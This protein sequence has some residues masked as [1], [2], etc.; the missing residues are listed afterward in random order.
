MNRK[1]LLHKR[2]IITGASM[3][4]GKEIAI[5]VAKRGGTPILIARSKEKLQSLSIELETQF[6]VRAPYYQIDVG[7]SASIKEGFRKIVA[8]ETVDVLINNAG[9]GIFAYFE[10]MEMAEAEEMFAVNVLGLIACTKA[11]LPSMIAQKHGQ[12]INIASQAGKLAT[13]KSSVYAATKH[14]VLGFSNSLRMEVA[15]HNLNVSTVNPGPIRTSFYARADRAGTY[16]QNVG[17]WL[18]SSE[19][20]AKRVVD[21]IEKPRREVNMPK[22]MNIAATLYQLFP[23]LV[24]KLG[25]KQFNKK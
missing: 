7:D 3:G 24:E 10:E 17:K 5:E 12:I 13:P 20:V 21:L 15:P 9:F 23:T 16:E 2:V 25:K 18:L 14:A 19:I 22:L 1:T 6:H 8:G 4:L 11:V